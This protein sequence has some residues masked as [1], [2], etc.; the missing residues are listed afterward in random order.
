LTYLPLTTSVLRSA[1]RL[2]A[3]ARFKGLPTGAS[4]DADVI[5]AAQALEIPG[6]VVVTD[7]LKH[8]ER[9]VPAYRWQDVP[10]S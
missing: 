1:S 10:L 5:L 9:F 6:A 2:W 3:E 8:L 4:L 7:N